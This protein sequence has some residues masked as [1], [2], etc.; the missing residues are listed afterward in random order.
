MDRRFLSDPAVVAASRRFV[1][2]RLKTYESAEEAR[3]LTSIFVG[4][5]GQLE[6]TTFALLAPDGRTLLARPGRSPD[7]AFEDAA[8]MAS[9]M[10]DAAADR[11]GR[12]GVALPLPLSATVRLA[13]D[14]AACDDLPLVVV[15]ARGAE[16]RDA[17]VARLAAPAWGPL[18]G[19]A[20]WAATLE[21]RDLGAI[22]GDIEPGVLVIAP[23]E[24]GVDGAVLERLP[25]DL[26]DAALAVRLSA[27][28]S[29][30]RA[31]PARDTRDHIREG[32][33]QGVEW[34]TAIPETD[35]GPRGDRAPRPGRPP[36]R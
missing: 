24:F 10:E 25:S 16:E 20:V 7:F 18:A 9:F 11:P 21:R 36:G 6:N 17:L 28:L 32:R 12:P 33:R 3:V 4:G 34:T 35:P 1:C 13:L 2:I 5:S 30:Y 8:D 14:V 19:R 23:G 31:P 26:D 22:E 15:H 27:A 29:R